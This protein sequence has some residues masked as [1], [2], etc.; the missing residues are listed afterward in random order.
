LWSLDV[1]DFWQAVERRN[2]WRRLD[3]AVADIEDDRVFPVKE[4]L[5]SAMCIGACSI[6]FRL[7]TVAQA[8]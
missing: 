7:R 5:A 2:S 8:S 6:A 3:I 4:W 1:T